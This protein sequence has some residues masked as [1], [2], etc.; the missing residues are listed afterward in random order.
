[1]NKKQQKFAD[2]YLSSFNAT[3]S[4]IKAGYSKQSAHTQGYRLLKYPDIKTYISEELAKQ[5]ELLPDNTELKLFF[6]FRLKFCF[7]L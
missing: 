4:A 1:M 5:K 6:H 2:F 3:Q 7:T